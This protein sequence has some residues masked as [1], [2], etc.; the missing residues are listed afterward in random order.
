MCVCVRAC[1]GVCRHITC[2][3]CDEVADVLNEFESWSSHLLNIDRHTPRVALGTKPI[4]RVW[5]KCKQYL[6]K[7][8]SARG[9]GSIGK[10]Y[11]ISQ[12]VAKK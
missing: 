6:E 5:C 1:V 9:V 8:E 11:L 12:N 3:L 7:T 2:N 4:S 10:K